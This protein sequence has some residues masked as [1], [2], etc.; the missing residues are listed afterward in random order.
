M[1]SWWIIV[2]SKAPDELRSDADPKN[3]AIATWETGVDG[4]DWLKALVK[5]GKA[6]QLSFNGYPSNFSAKAKDV[7]PLFSEDK[8]P[9]KVGP[10][11]MFDGYDMAMN[12]K[13]NFTLYKDR[14][15][16][17]QPEQVLT[18]SVWDQT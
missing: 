2:Y 18:I 15:I 6:T 14:L 9:G 10:P 11:V 8:P 4:T 1:A 16:A 13:R 17:C 5:D 7:L 12:W 3:E